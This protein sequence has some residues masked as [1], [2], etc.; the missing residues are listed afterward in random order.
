MHPNIRHFAFK[1]LLVYVCLQ[2]SK[3][4]FASIIDSKLKIGFL[5]FESKHNFFYT[6]I[7]FSTHFCSNVLKHKPPY[8]QLKINYFPC[9]TKQCTFAYF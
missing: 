9:K 7:Y 1:L 6:K 3:I 8:I 4:D 2:R 5:A